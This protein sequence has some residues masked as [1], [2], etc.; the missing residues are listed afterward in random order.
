[1]RNK[2]RAWDSSSPPKVTTKLVPSPTSVSCCFAAMVSIFAAGCS[3]SSSP[4][5]VAASLVIK[6]FSRWLI[7]NLLM[8]LGPSD[9]RVISARAPHASMFLM[10]ASTPPMVL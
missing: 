2:S 3:T 8:P 5:T 9:V 6:T 7:T 1:M 4:T 10:T